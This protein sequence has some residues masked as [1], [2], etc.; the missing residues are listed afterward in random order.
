MRQN[1]FFYSLLSRSHASKVMS[2]QLFSSVLLSNDGTRTESLAVPPTERIRRSPKQPVN[3]YLDTEGLMN[4]ESRSSR[5]TDNRA[6]LKVGEA[7]KSGW[8]NTNETEEK[9]NLCQ[10]RR[11]GGKQNSGV[12][13][14]FE[15]RRCMFDIRASVTSV[16]R[17]NRYDHRRGIYW[18]MMG[19]SF[20]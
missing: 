3:G 8:K 14:T 20:S 13:K 6:S 7:L 11:R 18:Q 19:G 15:R 17:R 12:R 10:G 2:N 4:S 16:S 1:I 5:S 9:E